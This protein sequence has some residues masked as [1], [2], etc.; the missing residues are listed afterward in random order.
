MSFCLLNIV[1]LSVAIDHME[2]I[3]LGKAAAL[4]QADFFL[5][6]SNLNTS[7]PTSNRFAVLSCAPMIMVHCATCIQCSSL[8]P[9]ERLKCVVSCASNI[10][11]SE[12]WS[13][14]ELV[15]SPAVHAASS[16]VKKGYDKSRLCE[17]ICTPK[18]WT[19]ESCERLGRLKTLLSS[20]IHP[21][22]V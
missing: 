8:R 14:L 20:S 18:S 4:R 2:G 13:I 5:H 3:I 15:P 6:K 16:R 12:S 11:L 21:A 9:R 17:F 10:F 22:L 7:S 1:Q 19:K